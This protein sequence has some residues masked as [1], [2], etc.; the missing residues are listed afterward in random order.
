MLVGNN[1]AGGEIGH[2]CVN[3]EEN[4]R[5]GCGNKRVFGTV[6]VCYGNCPPGRTKL[7]T[8]KRETILNKAAIT[9]KDVFDAVKAGDEVADE[10]AAEF[11]KYLGYGLANL[12]GSREPGSVCH[13]REAFPK[14]AKY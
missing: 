14:P 6:C 11:G 4:D 2:I 13:R 9:A 7:K 10:I 12:C 5:C 3:Y 1:G 8:E